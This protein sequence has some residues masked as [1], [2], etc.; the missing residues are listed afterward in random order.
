MGVRFESGDELTTQLL[1]NFEYLDVPFDILRNGRF[2]VPVGEYPTRG[3]RVEFKS[4]AF[5]RIVGTMAHQRAGF[6]TGTRRDTEASVTVRPF[7]GTNITANWQ[8]NSAQLPG[9]GFEAQVYRLFS[10]FDFTPLVSLNLNVQYDNV[11]R[12]LGTQNRLTWILTP[13][14][15]VFLV[16]QHNWRNPLDERLQTL[17]QQANLKVAIT[18]RF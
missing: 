11:S 18:Q 3:A 14:N 8:H 16:Y 12:L 15:R 7:A 10:S 13:G 2:V 17:Q 4:A 1:W 6:W 9:G 5:R